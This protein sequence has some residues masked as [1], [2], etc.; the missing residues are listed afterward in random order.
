MSGTTLITGADG[1]LGCKLATALLESCDD[2]LVL[3]MRADS[4]AELSAK[5]H[6]LERL[7]GPALDGRGTFAVA[8][9]RGNDPFCD[10]NC[11]K[12]TRIV[13][14][15]AVT[16]FNVEY[17]L[18]RRVNLEGTVRVCTFA[19]RCENLQRIAVLSTLYSAGRRKGMVS[20]TLHD[21]VGF[22][23][24]YEWSKWAAECHALQSCADLPVSVLRLPTIIADDVSGR[25]TQYNAFHNTL[26]LFFYGLL[27]LV[28]GD[29]STP[30][31][32]AT[33]SFAAEA[34]SHLL[35]SAHCE[36][37]YHICY[38][39]AHT[40]TLSLLIDTVFDVFACDIGFQRR[41][42]LRPLYCD[43]DSFED[44]VEA[45]QRLRGGPL[46]ESLRSVA[47]FGTQLYLPKAFSN[48]VLRAAWPGYHVDDPIALIRSTCSHLVATR[49]GRQNEEAA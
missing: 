46:N 26:K 17:D 6:R 22:V 20:E 45:A 41:K 5:R 14:A 40:P 36:G 10:V 42:I 32:L 9:I 30:L 39:T 4:S 27:S 2:R 49:W 11:K 35:N 47:P 33:A 19:S 34:T 13:H 16:R 8:D 37:I 15:A 21:N 23:N 3:A 1:Y 43:Q 25:V 44:L 7:I 12:I 38:D 29:P 18:A 24:H 28:P 31:S 48:N